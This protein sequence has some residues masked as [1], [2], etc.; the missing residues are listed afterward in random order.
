MKTQCISE[1]QAKHH[2]FI[3]LSIIM[4]YS[5]LL[6]CDVCVDCKELWVIFHIEVDNSVVPAPSALQAFLLLEDWKSF[7]ISRKVLFLVSGTTRK[8]YV[9]TKEQMAKNTRKQY[10]CSPICANITQVNQTF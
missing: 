8:M 7:W 1:V 6:C 5:D 4:F 3:A 2:H 10:C 9:A